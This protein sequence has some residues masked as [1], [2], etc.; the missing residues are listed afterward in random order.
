MH[1]YEPRGFKD[2]PLRAAPRGFLRIMLSELRV[3]GCTTTSSAQRVFKDPSVPVWS[4]S[5]DAWPLA[6][7]RATQIENE[8]EQAEHAF[9]GDAPVL[10]AGARPGCG[11]ALTGAPR[12]RQDVLADMGPTVWLPG[13][14]RADGFPD[15][16][17]DQSRPAPSPESS[18]L[19]VMLVRGQAR[20]RGR[21]TR[22]S[23]ARARCELAPAGYL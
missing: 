8:N 13:A 18:A 6:A 17:P 10:G 1:H 21:R 22:R 4:G 15:E 7:L 3:Q 9:D 20:T 11:K 23:K 2:A 19:H 5:Q 14:R 16:R 12:A